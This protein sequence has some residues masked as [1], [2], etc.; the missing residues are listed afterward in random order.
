VSERMDDLLGQVEAGGGGAD[1]ASREEVA[2]LQ[3]ELQ[4]VAVQASP[5]PAGG[6][7]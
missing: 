4:A 3:A 7:E 5:G 2:G 6:G 1:Q